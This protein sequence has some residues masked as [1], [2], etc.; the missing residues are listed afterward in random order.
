M[1]NQGAEMESHRIG[2]QDSILEKRKEEKTWWTTLWLKGKGIN[3]LKKRKIA[4][5]VMEDVHVVLETKVSGTRR[6]I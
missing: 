1:W 2:K 6:I 5:N 4:L 3:A